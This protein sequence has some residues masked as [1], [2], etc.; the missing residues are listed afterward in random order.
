NQVVYKILN[1]ILGSNNYLTIDRENDIFIF[2]NMKSSI[3]FDDMINDIKK[4]VENYNSKISISIGISTIYNS[5]K[6]I[7]ELY[8]ES[9]LASLFC[10]DGINYYKS[11]N[12]MKL[13]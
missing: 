9:Y 2:L 10:E 12:T 4:K 1:N 11:L 6:E 5:L 8:N 3:Y 13:L 7:E